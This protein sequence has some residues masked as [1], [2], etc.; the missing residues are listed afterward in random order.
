MKEKKWDLGRGCVRSSCG[1]HPSEKVQE[2]L[3][4]SFTNTCM[5]TGGTVIIAQSL[6]LIHA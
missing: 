1:L 5:R 4:Q 6:K 2:L 3:G